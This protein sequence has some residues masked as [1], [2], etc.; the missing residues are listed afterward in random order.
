MNRLDLILLPYYN[1]LKLKK[2]LKEK[3]GLKKFKRVIG[4]CEIIL[5]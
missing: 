5:L 4:G 3:K 1:Q 2:A